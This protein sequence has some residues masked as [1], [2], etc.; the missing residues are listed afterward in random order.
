MARAVV[1]LTILSCAD[2][3]TIAQVVPFREYMDP[4]L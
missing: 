4:R 1:L 2:Q 3:R